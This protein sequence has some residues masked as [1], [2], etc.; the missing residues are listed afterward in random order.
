VPTAIDLA[1]QLCSLPRPTL[2]ANRSLVD[3][4]VPR[5]PR[6]VADRAEFLRAQVVATADATEGFM[7]F[8]EKR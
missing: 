1:R 8:A 7:R 3:A 6:D 4:L 2:L 5:M